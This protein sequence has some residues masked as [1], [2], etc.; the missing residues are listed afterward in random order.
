VCNKLTAGKEHENNE[1][2]DDYEWLDDELWTDEE[3]A[4]DFEVKDEPYNEFFGLEA[5]ELGNEDEDRDS[6]ISDAE[7]MTF[8]DVGV[9]SDASDATL[10]FEDEDS[11]DDDN[12]FF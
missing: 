5:G 10:L 12:D 3:S 1:E 8:E 9:L 11:G 4:D 6:V 2:S 7:T